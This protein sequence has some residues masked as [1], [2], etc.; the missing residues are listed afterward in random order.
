ME[1]DRIPIFINDSCELFD[2]PALVEDVVDVK[3]VIELK[4]LSGNEM[5]V[6]ARHENSSLQST[7]V[8][9]DIWS[10]TSDS[11]LVGSTHPL[12]FSRDEP[13]LVNVPG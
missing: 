6:L 10:I 11:R 12:S 7:R 9:N 8:V 2:I 3:A 4:D 13:H 5:S 1:T